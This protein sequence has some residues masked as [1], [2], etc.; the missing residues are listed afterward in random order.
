VQP[1][2]LPPLVTREAPL[3]TLRLRTVTVRRG[4]DLSRILRREY[5]YF[6]PR[7]VR[8]V[9]AANPQVYDWDYLEIGQRLNLPLDPEGD[10]PSRRQELR[11]R[12][13]E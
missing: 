13:P 10:V 8:I 12:I 5:G 2:T 1:E 7:L 6:N 9:Q 3:D 4:D 11:R